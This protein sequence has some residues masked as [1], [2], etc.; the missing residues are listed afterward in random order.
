MLDLFLLGPY[1]VDLMRRCC[2]SI[3]VV[4][5]LTRGAQLYVP[6]AVLSGDVLRVLVRGGVGIDA[7]S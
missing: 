6:G 2:L 5:K 3:S 1:C 7:Q 4:W